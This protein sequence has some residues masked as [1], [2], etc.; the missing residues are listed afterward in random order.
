M[1]FEPVKLPKLAPDL[2]FFGS[3]DESMLSEFFRQQGEAPE[4]GP[5]LLELSTS[6]GEADIGRRIALEL[7]LWQEAGREIWFLG[8]TFVYSAGRWL[9]SC[10]HLCL[11]PVG[12][13]TLLAS[14]PPPPSAMVVHFA[15]RNHA[16][17]F[18]PLQY[19]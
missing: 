13:H 14:C 18:W 11:C 8:K 6:G 3:V 9:V 16:Y 2:R 17:W 4:E 7:R 1:E 15:G 10:K 19:C 12:S 5:I